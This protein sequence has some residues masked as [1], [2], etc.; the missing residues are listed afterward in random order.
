MTTRRHVLRAIGGAVLLTA[1][2]GRDR[3]ASPQPA[4]A[5]PDGLIVAETRSG[6]VT[7]RGDRRIAHG[8]GAVGSGD[9]GRVYAA[10]ADGNSTAL[11]TVD[12]RTGDQVGRASLAGAWVPRVVDPLGR[13]AAFTPPGPAGSG[14]SPTDSTGAPAGRDHTPILIAGPSGEQ[15]R[16]D[17]AGNFQPDAVSLDGEALFVLEWLPAQA[18]DRYRVRMVDLPSGAVQPL[19]TRDKLPVPA[20]AEEEMRGQGRQA[21]LS[22][23][24]ETLYTLYTHQADHQ[25][26]RDLVAGRPGGVHAFVHVL[27]LTLRWAYCLDLPEPFGQGPAAGHAL[28]LRPDGKRLLVVDITGG[29]LAEADTESLTLTGVTAAPTGTGTASLAATPSR[30]LLGIGTRVHAIDSTSATVA[31]TAAGEIRGLGVDRVG[32]KLAVADPNGVTWVDL[33]TGKAV[34]RVPVDG[35]TSLVSAA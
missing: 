18:P 32:T 16:F 24:R 35:L 8:S 28:A 4:V 10:R 26:T 7:V 5:V 22:P 21:V 17:L 25:H 2:G 3:A 14:G 1:C 31:W 34:G 33:T 15:R 11:V 12:S 20:G 6:L 19:L 23:D 13:L 9:G 27:H 29:R 30:A